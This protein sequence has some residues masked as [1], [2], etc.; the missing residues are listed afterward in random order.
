[1]AFERQGCSRVKQ[2]SVSKLTEGLRPKGQMPKEEGKLRFV[3][4]LAS[5]LMA[6]FQSDST[7][8]PPL[9]CRTR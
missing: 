1:M 5:K 8:F 7:L 9:E 2:S 4:T 6:D 3:C